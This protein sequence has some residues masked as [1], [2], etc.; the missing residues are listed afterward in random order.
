VSVV[1]FRPWA[2]STNYV[3]DLPKA[4]SI[5]GFSAA[6]LVHMVLRMVRP[7][8]RSG[9]SFI[10]YRRR[11]PSDVQKI[12]AGREVSIRLKRECADKPLAVSARLGKEVKFSLRT[13]DPS[14]AKERTAMATAH[15]ERLYEALRKGPVP[16][17]PKQRVALSGILY[18]A[19]ANNL[20]DDPVDPKIWK[21]ILALNKEAMEGHPLTIGDQ[22]AAR[23]KALNERF[24]PF[25]DLV[26]RQ[27]G[28]VTD[29]DSRNAL[30]KE[31]ARA[32][33]EAA[34][35]LLRN[36]HGDYRPDPNGER[37]PK[38][39]RPLDG[40]ASK[41]RNGASLTFKELF[42]R[43]R[44]E[45]R[46]S[47][48]T[49]STWQGCIRALQKH[50]GHDNPA[51]VTKA[52]IIAWKDALL[53]AGYSPNGIRNGQLTAARTLFKYGADNDLL[54][55]NPAQGVTVHRKVV[56]G[57]RMLPYTDAEVAD[58]LAIADRQ[59]NPTRR[60][61]P[62][63]MALSGARVGEVAQLW[64]KRIVEVDGVVVMKIAP[65]ERFA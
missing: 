5:K 7:T 38:W 14:V 64:G 25:V 20:E 39:E 45:R 12:A 8:R 13:R 54:T 1:R 35:K 47:A 22:G 3:I 34:E 49:V 9:S 58:L 16:L 37:F 31:T 15:L 41:T 27:E 40:G 65:A 17:T 2:P 11:V 33:T 56:A 62:W 18:R 53:A 48:S 42:E 24:G 50:L 52:D 61:L 28:I 29:E 60:W 21:R 57:S 36:A 55:F 51:R 63:L 59:S 46:P 26:L 10:Q 44:L 30:L 6:Q 19:F 4:L 32:L 23:I 43:W